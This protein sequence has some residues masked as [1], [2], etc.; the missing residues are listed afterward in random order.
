MGT[1]TMPKTTTTSTVT[2]TTHTTTSTTT[3]P[4]TVIDIR[5]VADN[6]RSMEEPGNS[7]RSDYDY[8]PTIPTESMKEDSPIVSSDS[9][10]VS[11]DSDSPA[12]SWEPLDQESDLDSATSTDE[13]PLIH[14]PDEAS[15]DYDSD[16]EDED[17]LQRSA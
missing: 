4:V 17:P 11:S 5:N 6:E 7:E 12:S 10:S 9:Y 16:D 3:E 8:E 13:D 14:Y 15:G 1:T 2:T